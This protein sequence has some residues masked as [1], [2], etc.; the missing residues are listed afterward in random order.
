MGFSWV[1]VLVTKV[2][3]LNWVLA[4]FKSQHMGSS[5]N[6]RQ[7]VSHW[8]VQREMGD[9]PDCPVVKNL[10][11]NGGDMGSI[12]EVQEDPTC[13]GESKPMHH[14]YWSPW[15]GE[16]VIHNYW[17]HILQLLKPVHLEPTGA[18]VASPQQREAT[19]MRSLWGTTRE[20]L[21]ATTKTQCSQN[22]F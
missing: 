1:Q 4:G 15:A 20:S 10:P 17:A 6:L 12:S 5:P 11:V 21:H 13:L 7:M 2:W 22:F 16:P 9:F 14:N 18:Q 19:A 8:I 3:V